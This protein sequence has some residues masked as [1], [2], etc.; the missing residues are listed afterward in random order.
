MFIY[1]CVKKNANALKIT[2]D[3]R[4]ISQFRLAPGRLRVEAIH[5]PSH[6]YL[7]YLSTLS[8]SGIT[9]F[10]LIFMFVSVFYSELY[11][12][13]IIN[14]HSKHDRFIKNCVE[15]NFFI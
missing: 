12:T 5:T 2:G 3:I 9:I 14:I 10:K 7:Y 13:V 15:N 4:K 8:Y 1:K 6:N 11:K